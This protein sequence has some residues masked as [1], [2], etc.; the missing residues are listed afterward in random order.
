MGALS[1][2]CGASDT[3]LMF[4]TVG[5]V[6]EDAVR[7][8]PDREALIVR[9]QGVRLTYREL[10]HRVDNVA[11]GLVALGFQA[12]DRIGNHRWINRRFGMDDRRQCRQRTGRQ[13]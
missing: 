4:K 13:H 10:N 11:A 8:W 6:L 5:G 9:H 3:P 2:V 1:Y 7:Q 12:G